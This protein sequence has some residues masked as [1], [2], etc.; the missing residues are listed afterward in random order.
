MAKR[1]HGQTIWQS[2]QPNTRL[3]I[4][5]R[6]STGMGPRNSMVRYEMQRRA[7]STYGPTNAWVG[8]MSRQ[9]WQRPQCSLVVA[10]ST[11]SGRSTN[12]SARKK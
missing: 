6:S 2:S 8:Q 9:A 7:S 11:G 4:F 5:D 1:F 3:P 10:S 12:S